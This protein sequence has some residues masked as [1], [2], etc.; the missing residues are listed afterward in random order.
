M[1]DPTRSL[2]FMGDYNQVTFLYDASEKDFFNPLLNDYQ[3]AY[4][5]SPIIAENIANKILKQRLII[6]AG[7]I[8]SD[9][10]ALARHL[11]WLVREKKKNLT[12]TT[13]EQAYLPVYEWKRSGARFVDLALEAYSDPAIFILPDLLPQ[14]IS[15]NLQ[16]IREIVRQRHIVIITTDDDSVWRHT[17][18]DQF[19]IKLIEL[20]WEDLSHIDL[21]NRKQLTRLL[22]IKLLAAKAELPT[23]LISNLTS[24]TVPYLLEDVRADEV[25]ARLKTPE[26]I[27]YFIS[28]LSFETRHGEINKALIAASIQAVQDD[29]RKI[30]Q[31]YHSLDA[32]RQRLLVLALNFFD[33]MLD[34]QF[35]AA[36]EA[37]IDQAWYRR[38]SGLRALDYQ[39][40]ELLQRFFDYV[41]TREGLAI[42]TRLRNQRQKLLKVA[43]KSYRRHILSARPV[44]YDLIKGSVLRYTDNW[45]LY[46]SDDRRD[47][48]RKAISETISD[49]GLE[50]SAAI[51]DVLL[52]LAVDPHVG[53][54]AV[55]A[56]AVARWREHNASAETF[57]MLHRWMYD[58]TIEKSISSF[59]LESDRSAQD[60]PKTYLKGTI[61]LA[62]GYAAQADAPN[63]MAPELYSLLDELSHEQNELILDKLCSYTLSM[64]AP[65]HLM[66]IQDVV[67]SLTR[68]AKQ[69]DAI[70]KSMRAAYYK[71]PVEVRHI[72][73]YWFHLCIDERNRHQTIK[74]TDLT[75]LLACVAKI[76]G[77]L[78]Y[79]EVAGEFSIADAYERL[80]AILQKVNLPS[81]RE[82]SL[83]S[84]IG[85]SRHHFTKLQDIVPVVNS[86]E[87][88]QIV[89]KLTEIYLDQRSQIGK[90]QR[91]WYHKRTRRYYSI[92]IG[93][94]PRPVTL[95][96]GE[97]L[98]W[99]RDGQNHIAQQIGVRALAHFVRTL[100]LD[101]AKYIQKLQ[102]TD[103]EY[104]QEEGGS[105]RRW[106][107]PMITTYR[108]KL[109][110]WLVLPTIVSPL[111]SHHRSTIRGILPEVIR[112]NS[113]SQKVTVHLLS[114]WQSLDDDDMPV[115]AGKLRFVL[116]WD[117]IG[118]R[119]LI[120]SLAIVVSIA[121]FWITTQF[122]P[123][124]ITG[125]FLWILWIHG[126][127]WL[128]G[129]IYSLYR[130]KY[131]Q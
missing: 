31:W 81:I 61:A 127:L 63:K 59:L 58:S 33:G 26:N 51:E 57:K 23:S 28:L 24:K 103:P 125:S 100:D 91:R 49:I 70:A 72:V 102:E 115:I 83:Q 119:W 13:S 105:A 86:K 122:W 85:L 116:F 66:Q 54:Q 46:G 3:P 77:A 79:N 129:S 1:S 106:K 104:Y 95:I 48:L 20:I 124:L 35:F 117:S 11:A 64:I 32:N 27:D 7:D 9:K 69:H 30:Y 118:G 50:N 121:V 29:A 92:W 75:S 19:S 130:W 36:L 123:N 112:Q 84:A 87:M 56:R 96:E 6:L 17:F 109:W 113:R 4:Y 25:A 82:P 80:R 12:A 74:G 94:D 40:F 114:D 68:N 45:E 53:V 101:E 73:E 89:S 18:S 126:I 111:S 2:A 55:A 65:L 37:L 21:Y 88:G 110:Y 107:S 128:S 22:I 62:I 5:E 67:L 44:F 71:Q 8:S 52:H 10:N 99:V 15:Y 60:E 78:P 39:D 38:D 34:D 98:E 43:W 14:H 108:R 120:F 90:G 16:R 97:M 41:P 93:D 47:Q 42:K 76:Y 131:D